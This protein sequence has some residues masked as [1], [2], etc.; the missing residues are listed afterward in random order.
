[1]RGRRTANEELSRAQMRN[2]D[3]LVAR[4]PR[5]NNYLTNLD[6]N[7]LEKKL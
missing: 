3:V 6:D 2:L 1:M 5:K 4:D 7:F